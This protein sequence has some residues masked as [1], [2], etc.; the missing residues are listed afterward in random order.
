MTGTLPR[1]DWF[2]M[3]KTATNAV[4]NLPGLLLHDVCVH[5]NAKLSGD[6]HPRSVIFSASLVTRKD[7]PE[8]VSIPP[9]EISAPVN[10]SSVTMG[11]PAW[12]IELLGFRG[13]QFSRCPLHQ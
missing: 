12:F 13:T 1:I 5:D 9:D 10:V 2:S 7:L 4:N 6:R 11:K 8:S 3:N